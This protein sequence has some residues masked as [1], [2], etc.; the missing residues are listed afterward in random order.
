MEY[1]GHRDLESVYDHL[2]MRETMG[3]RHGTQV[4]D[5]AKAGKAMYDLAVH[6]DPPLRIVLG[7]DAFGA[8]ETKVKTYGESIQKWKSVSLGTD[9]DED[10]K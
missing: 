4:G 3:K 2:N 9:V 8:M 6:A 7:S 10:K 1:G 5:P